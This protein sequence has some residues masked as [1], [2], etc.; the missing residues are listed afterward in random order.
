MPQR[1]LQAVALPLGLPGSVAR[2][3][4]V[5]EAERGSQSPAIMSSMASN[6]LILTSSVEGTVFLTGSY[7]VKVV[8]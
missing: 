4:G 2:Q 8:D 5:R 1:L 7:V 6:V 3:R